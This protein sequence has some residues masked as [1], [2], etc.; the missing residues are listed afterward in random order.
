VKK[1]EAT[2]FNQMQVEFSAGALSQFSRLLKEGSPAA[3]WSGT[4]AIAAVKRLLKG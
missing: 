3:S 4:M 1:I 2:V